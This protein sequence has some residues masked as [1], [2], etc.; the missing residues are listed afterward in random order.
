MQIKELI[1]LKEI[2]RF[3]SEK[4]K[5]GSFWLSYLNHKKNTDK[6]LSVRLWGLS[7]Q[8]KNKLRDAF[9]S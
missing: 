3:P 9:Y 2:S 6:K 1:I 4:S 8:I 5:K 7:L